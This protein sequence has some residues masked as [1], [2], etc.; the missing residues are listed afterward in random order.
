MEYMMELFGNM[1]ADRVLIAIAAIT[2][3]GGCYKKISNYFGAKA[4]NDYKQAQEI[5]KVIDQSRN[6]P[7]WR[8]QSLDIQKE[9]TE[10]IHALNTKMDGLSRA[11]GEGMACTWRYRIL[12]FDD[13]LRHD[14]KHSHEH[15]DQ[16]LED[17]DS[18]EKYCR[19]NPE[20]P[21]SKAKKAIENIKEVY[22]LCA[23]ENKFL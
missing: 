8:Q 17:I 10:Q 6:Y 21:N 4:V 1:T 11:S 9:L 14:L 15:F 16:I 22:D 12:R 3:M 5:Q 19:D 20:F 13:E 18:Y 23:D 7:I 2:F